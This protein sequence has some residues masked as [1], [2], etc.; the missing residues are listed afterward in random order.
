M[1][2]MEEEAT[3]ISDLNKNLNTMQKNLQNFI[4]ESCGSLGDS[5]NKKLDL[6][7]NDLEKRMEI[8][9]KRVESVERIVDEKVEMRMNAYEKDNDDRM[10]KYETRLERVERE[11]VINRVKQLCNNLLITKV[12]MNKDA[13]NGK[14]TIEQ[15]IQQV[16]EVLTKLGIE[17]MIKNFICRRIPQKKEHERFGPP[18]VHLQLSCTHHRF[19]IF[20]ALARNKTDI[21]VEVELPACLREEKKKLKAMAY[22]I[23][24]N[25]GFKTKTQ[26]TVEG[27][28][29]VL[30]EKKEGETRFTKV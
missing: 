8:L 25:S 23:R 15:T 28:R 12:P 5:L 11:M 18:I 2:K 30:L 1:E 29:V 26:V 17:D 13:T 10:K 27:H 4:L 16:T 3:S 20:R 14:E 19:L 24:K 22:D 7:A 9:D 21:G 6:I